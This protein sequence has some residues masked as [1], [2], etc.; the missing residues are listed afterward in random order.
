MFS[1]TTKPDVCRTRLASV[2]GVVLV[3]ATLLA[4][5][6]TADATAKL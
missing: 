6:G 2:L 5:P 1:H 3:A 4:L